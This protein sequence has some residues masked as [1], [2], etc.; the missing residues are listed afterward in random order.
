MPTLQKLT[1]A[2]FRK[3]LAG[4]RDER[5]SA[6]FST[7]AFR[8]HGVDF[9]VALALVFNRRELDVKTLWTRIDSAIT[10]G[11]TEANGNDTHR[12]I[13]AACG[14]VLASPNAVVSSEF[15][16]L[17]SGIFAMDE[18]ESYAFVRHLAKSRYTLIAFGRQ[19]W[20]ER[21]ELR[22]AAEAFAAESE[23]AE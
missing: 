5:G 9:V 12:L 13:D 10:T 14:H 3:Q 23:V 6:A 18:D 21:K 1:P 19:A 4:L 11:I 22:K 20:E 17:T 7:D 2:E 15:Q 16:S 8:Q